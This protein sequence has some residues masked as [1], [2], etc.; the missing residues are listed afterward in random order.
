MPLLF[1]R[2]VIV[3][4]MLAS[5]SIAQFLPVH[6]GW[7]NGFIESLQLSFLLM[8]ATSAFYFGY[9]ESRVQWRWF[10]FMVVPIWFLLIGREMSWGATLLADPLSIHSELGPVYSSSLLLDGFKLVTRVVAV[11]MLF[12]SV[13]IFVMSKQYLSI[14]QLHKHKMMPWFELGLALIALILCHAAEGR[15]LFEIKWP[16]EGHLQTL[17]E[18]FEMWVYLLILIAQIRVFDQL[19]KK[20]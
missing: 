15:G 4:F 12:S 3:F 14:R 18:L 2:V 6:A 11:L 9:N 5:Y 16:S 13:L 7:E 10:A 19:I 20:S 8:G 17:E 1:I